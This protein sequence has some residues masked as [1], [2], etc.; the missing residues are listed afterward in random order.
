MIGCPKVLE[1]VSHGRVIR[2][3][4][5][6]DPKQQKLVAEFELPA[7]ES[8]W[9]AARTTA[10]NGAVAHTSPVYVIVDG[11]SFLD[12]SQLP[13]LVAKELKVL[14]YVEKRMHDKRFTRGYARRGRRV[15]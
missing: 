4:E 6:A 8:Q 11:A 14:D 13:Q 5:S 1:V 7:G 10:F 12:R 15:A 3:V 2:S 9:L